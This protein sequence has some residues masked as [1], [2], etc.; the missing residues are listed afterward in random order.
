MVNN[1]LNNYILSH[2]FFI[3]IV[4]YFSSIVL[5]ILKLHLININNLISSL[6]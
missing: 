1:S 5:K 2:F 6:N 3:L 4:I